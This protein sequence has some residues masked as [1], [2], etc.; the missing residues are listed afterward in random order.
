MGFAENFEDLQIWQRSRV[1][2]NEI[3][4]VFAPNPS[5]PWPASC[6]RNNNR[7]SKAGGNELRVTG[8]WRNTGGAAICRSRVVQYFVFLISCDA[9]PFTGGLFMNLEEN[10]LLNF[11]LNETN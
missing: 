11:L 9:L 2:T 1:L 4:D 7:T 5:A 3:Y 8:S 10:K 6:A